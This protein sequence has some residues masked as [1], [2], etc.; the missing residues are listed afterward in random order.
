MKAAGIIVSSIGLVDALEGLLVFVVAL[1]GSPFDA[2][3]QLQLALVLVF[4]GITLLALQ[5][6]Y[7]KKVRT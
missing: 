3:Q 7:A 4:S 2:V 6:P 5:S 1:S